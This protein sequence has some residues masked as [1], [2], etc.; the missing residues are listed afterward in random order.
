V[1][2][3]TPNAAGWPTGLYWTGELMDADSA[4]YVRMGSGPAL[5]LAMRNNMEIRLSRGIPDNFVVCRRQSAPLPPA[6]KDKHR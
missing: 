4:A 5:E 6:E 1:A 3:Y 2:I